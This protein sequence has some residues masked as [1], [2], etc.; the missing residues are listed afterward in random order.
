MGV[1]SRH[2]SSSGGWGD[3]DTASGDL[4]L[5]DFENMK[6]CADH[7]WSDQYERVI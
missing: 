2:H 1:A 3:G 5:G 4:E 6:P 7:G